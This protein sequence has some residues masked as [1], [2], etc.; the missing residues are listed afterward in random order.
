M[1]GFTEHTPLTSPIRA[2]IQA[3][4]RGLTLVMENNMSPI[5]ITTESF[6]V[7]NMLTNN[8]LLY[9]DLIVQCRLSMRKQEIIRMKNVFHEQNRVAD[10]IS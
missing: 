1:V 9:D 7:I 6:D 5:E 4:R 2:E 10:K 3:M 8:N